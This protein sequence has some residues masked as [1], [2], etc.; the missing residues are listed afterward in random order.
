MKAGR[1]NYYLIT[2]IMLVVLPASYILLK[3]VFR[4]YLSNDILKRA[5]EPVLALFDRN[6]PGKNSLMPNVAHYT[7]IWK[8]TALVQHNNLLQ[9]AIDH[10]NNVLI[11]VETW[12]KGEAASDNVLLFTLGGGFDKQINALATLAA[13][14]SHQVYVRWDPDM[15]VPVYQYPWQ[16]Q[17][18][19]L[20][21]RAFNYV[22]AKLKLRAP[23]V[24]IV[25]GPSGY[26]GDTEYWP[27]NKYVDYVSVTLGSAAENSTDKYPH[28][29]NIAEMLRL[30]LHR[31]RFIN[32]AV[33][34]IGSK[35]ITPAN[36]N[37]GYLNRQSAYIAR[38]SDIIYSNNNYVDSDKKKPVR[39]KILVGV[40]DPNKRL[41][42]QK[43]ISLEHIFT[44]LGEVESGTFER[45]FNEITG[46]GHDVIVTMEPWRD[47]SKK[48]DTNVVK[49]IL[50]GRYDAVIRKLFAIIANTRQTVYLRFMHEM[51]IPIHRYAWQIQDPVSYINAYRYFM[52]FE[53][54]SPKNVKRVWG[55]AGDRGSIDFWPGDDVV[56]YISIAIYGLP[57]KN[58]TDA[59]KQEDFSTIFNR[60]FYRF[61]FV[62]KPIFITEFGVKGSEEF[63]DKWL[64]NAAK[65]I[66][67]N[68][69]I[70]GV[71]YF[72]LYDNPKAWGNIKA[73]DWSIS[74]RSMNKFCALL[75]N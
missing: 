60:K 47:T 64:Q 30:K 70:F 17:S 36:F 57:D 28:T 2:F 50:A 24:K 8:N 7:V 53:G 11:T 55:P 27:G 61:R 26:P 1:S 20:Y 29:A 63:Q 32:K 68:R 74:P 23:R 56:D 72:N 58:I 6:D 65:T 14:T 40:F 10:N 21:I 18:P 52:K 73:P 38:Y 54:G 12:L 19:G 39:Q 67:A 33:L 22:A 44:D 48:A 5:D 35:T 3:P 16:F 43:Q 45:K 25:W 46:R 4:S 59:N 62:D 31:L 71:C 69:A 37:I 66:S 75:K 15:E 42:D 9:E 41:I 49:S 34:I 13:S 51:E